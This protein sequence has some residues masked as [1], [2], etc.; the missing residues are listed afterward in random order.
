MELQDIFT[1]DHEA[2]LHAFVAVAKIL[3]PTANYYKIEE[4][5]S[6]TDGGSTG[7]VVVYG[8]DV[9]GTELDVEVKT[10]DHPTEGKQIVIEYK[11]E[12]D[13]IAW[14]YSHW[15]YSFNWVGL[16]KLSNIK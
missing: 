16:K 5:R 14:S 10:Y 4:V 7:D 11:N 15:F 1:K 2:F 12:E 3:C 8:Y 9:N 6:V 13:G